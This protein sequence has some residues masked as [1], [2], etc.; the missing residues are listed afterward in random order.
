MD[1]KEHLQLK[2]LGSILL[3]QVKMLA[4]LAFYNNTLKNILK[5]AQIRS[6]IVNLNNS[7]EA[8]FL[9]KIVEISESSPKYK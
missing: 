8:Q 2:I 6:Y 7:V 1:H 9:T 5:T 4:W 3:S